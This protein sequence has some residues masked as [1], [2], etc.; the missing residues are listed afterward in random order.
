MV[1]Q[2]AGTP[3]PQK[4]CREVHFGKPVIMRRVLFAIFAGALLMSVSVSAGAAALG[5]SA[6]SVIPSEVQQIISVDY[7][8]VLNSQTATELHD[9][10]LPDNLKQFENA[11]KGL[12]INPQQDIDQLTFVA[13]REK[14]E[15][16]TVGVA[17]GQF[18]LKKVLTRFKAR[19]I[20]PTKFH[21]SLL[22]PMGNGMTMSLL[23]ESTMLFGDP[24]GVK[25]AL[26]ARDGDIQ[27]LNSN[28][29]ILD[30]MPAVDSGAV[31][32]VLDAKGTQTMMSS[33]MGDV[34]GMSEYQT[35]SKRLLSSR[36]A[37][38]FGSGVNFDLDVITSD[39]MTATTLSTL[40]RA[41]VMFKK[42][43]ATGVEKMALENM[44]VDSDSNQLKF[45]FK[46]DE[47]QFQSL[48]NSDLFAAM[49][50]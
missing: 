16:R 45:H 7:R 41:G 32:S 21:T 25:S 1:A 50:R 34:A 3:R 22:Y 5:S 29:Q 47:K 2:G 30:L 17:Q 11:L 35:L 44:T 42:T 46:S 14:N 26:S 36:Y 33:A 39:N 10:V 31:W 43:Q 4:G 23:D 24:T 28:S 12:G 19:K 48:I 37:M 13:F 27:S 38:N 8:Q 40:A 15:L 6:R 9:R 20:A 49:I 18:S